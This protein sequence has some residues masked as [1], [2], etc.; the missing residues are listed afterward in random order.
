MR[1]ELRFYK[2][3]DL[4]LISLYAAGINLNKYIPAIIASY[5]KGEEYHLYIPFCKAMDIEKGQLIH[6]QVAITDQQSIVLLKQVKKGYR[7]TFVKTLIR[8][9]LLFQSFGAFLSEDALIRQENGRIFSLDTSHYRNVVEARITKKRLTMSLPK[10]TTDK[11]TEIEPEKAAVE[12]AVQTTKRHS[13]RNTEPSLKEQKEAL[14][15]KLITPEEGKTIRKDGQEERE[16]VRESMK[17]ETAD[18]EQPQQG[19]SDLFSIF[20]SMIEDT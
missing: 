13:E 6:T 19:S 18:A 7:N 20:S 4:D 9:A 12:K 10:K 2:R 3:F 8:D 5:A 11:E 1:L 14:K 16:S 15:M 17:P